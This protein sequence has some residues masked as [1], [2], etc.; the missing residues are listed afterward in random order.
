MM[1][2]NPNIFAIE[3]E[4]AEVSEHLSQM[5]LG[6]FVLHITGRCYGVRQLDATM[7]GCSFNKVGRR[8][9]RRGSHNAPFLFD[10][11]AAEIAH[12]FRRAL[13]NFCKDDEKFFGMDQAQFEREVHSK[14]LEWAPDGD[15]A[16]DDG[17]FVLQIDFED[18]VRLIAFRSSEDGL[19]DPGS[20]GDVSL[21]Q[22]D[23]YGIL[24]GWKDKF[25][26]EWESMPKVFIG[27]P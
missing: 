4:I 15:E 14:S 2:G 7:L 19:F 8:I 13:Y 9:A 16:F 10:A 24:Q 11:G 1:I 3:S 17:S 12:A 5:A 25:V 22:D 6:Y 23:F 18:R 26:A 21:S 20:L 27:N